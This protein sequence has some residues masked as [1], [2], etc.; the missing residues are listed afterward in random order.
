MALKKMKKQIIIAVNKRMVISM[1][2][3][4]NGDFRMNYIDFCKFA[5]SM[6]G[7]N[8]ICHT[9]AFTHQALIGH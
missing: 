1:F 7:K 8:D 9:S 4:L 6:P 5:N 2:Y 3:L